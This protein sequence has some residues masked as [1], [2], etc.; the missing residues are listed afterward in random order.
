MIRI[1]ERNNKQLNLSKKQFFLLKLPKIK[2]GN[3]KI[4]DINKEEGI[5]N[6]PIRKKLFLK[7]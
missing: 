6:T 3:R 2:Q 4:D 5:K 7:L 1:P